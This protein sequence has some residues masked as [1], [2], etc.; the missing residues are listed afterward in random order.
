M[1]GFALKTTQEHKKFWS[2]RRIDWKTSYLDTFNHPHRFLITNILKGFKWLSLIEVGC[3]PGANLVRI[4]KDIPGRQV[5]G[6]DVNENAIELA[7]ETLSGALLK[8]GSVEDIM[9]SDNATDVILTDMCLIY[10]GW[11]RIH[12]AMEEIKRV[13]RHRVVFCELHSYSW[14]GRMRMWFS[15]GYYVHDYKKLLERYGF[16]DILFIKIPPEAWEGGEPQRTFGYIITAK[17]PKRK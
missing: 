6:I 3:G 8:V 12:R 17:V 4:V 2:E 1:A 16:D 7:K 13:A 14:W 9:M 10:V 5:G 15:S 11:R